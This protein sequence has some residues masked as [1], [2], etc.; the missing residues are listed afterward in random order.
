LTH[1]HAGRQNWGSGRRKDLP[2]R[3]GLAA[4]P[5]PGARPDDRSRRAAHL[6]FRGGESL[7]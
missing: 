2:A 6:Q 7:L 3:A 4:V 1:N 5:D